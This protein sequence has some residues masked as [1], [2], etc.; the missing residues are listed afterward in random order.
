MDST[1]IADPIVSIDERLLGVELLTR[2]IASD[3]RPLHPE[4]VISSWDLDRKR[5]FL[6]EQC[7]NIATMQTW[8]ERKNLFCT[9]NIDQ[10]MAFL[11]R[12]D[13]ILRQTFESMPFIKLELSEHFPGLD[14]GLKSPLLK[15]LSQGVNGLWLDDLGAGNANVVSLIEGYFEVV[16]ID[17]IFFNEQVK[18]PTFNQ[19]IASIKK[20]CGKVIIEGIENREH[21]GILREVGVWGLQGYLFKSVPFKNVDLLL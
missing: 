8:F 11:I 2:F 5:L 20:H 13:Y 19:L 17:R 15:S 10:K 1:F 16:K 3:G 7:G 4:F 6:Y 14:K 12:H 18:K 21:L 9:L